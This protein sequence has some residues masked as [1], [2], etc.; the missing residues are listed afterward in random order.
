MLYSFKEL[1][2]TPAEWTTGREKAGLTQVTAARSLGVSQPYLSQLEK[3]LRVASD[4]LARRAARLYKLPATA[5]PLPATQE[6]RDV[7]PNDLQ[8]RFAALGYPGF[9]HVRSGEVTNPAEAVLNV[10]V[11]RDLDTRLVEAVPWVLSTYT[12]LDWDWLRDH[13]KLRNAQNRLGYLVWLAYRTAYHTSDSTSRTLPA[14]EGA[15]EVLSKW[16]MELEEARLAGEGTLC[17][18]SMPEREKTWLRKNRPEAAV[19]WNLLTSL[20]ADQ[21]PYAQH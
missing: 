10:V 5:L 12:D 21:L 1:R 20:S 8:R 6:V 16:R 3:G 17:R 4:S 19:H 14:R 18:D 11:K 7:S 13:A 15:V 2:M 9:E